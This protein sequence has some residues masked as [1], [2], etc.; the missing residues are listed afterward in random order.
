MAASRVYIPVSTREYAQIHGISERTA[1]R[2]IAKA[3][4]AVKVGSRWKVPEPAS[5]VAKH[6][7]TSVSSVRKSKDALRAQNPNDLKDV[8]RQR[9]Q[10]FGSRSRTR[11]AAHYLDLL[12]KA[13]TARPANAEAVAERF[14]HASPAQNARVSRMTNVP[15]T[16][17]EWQELLDDDD[18]I[19][20]DGESIVRY[21]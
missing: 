13:K 19:G 1:R 3:D 6:R 2:R 10:N 17:E 5:T 8:I 7:G 12:A 4:G 15:A 20:D 16:K 18:F 14:K 9:V 21:H 11:A